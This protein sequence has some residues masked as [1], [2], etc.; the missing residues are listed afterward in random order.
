MKDW[1]LNEI[2]LRPARREDA[3]AIAALFLIAS[4]GLARYI[5]SRIDMPGKTLEEIGAAR[6]A[7]EGVAFSYRNCLVAEHEGRVVGMLHSFPMDRPETPETESD[8]VLRPYAELEDYGSLYISGLAILPAYCG[9]GLGRSLLLAAHERAKALGRPR[10][11]LI[12]FEAN[13]NAMRLYRAEGY[14]ELDRRPIVPH[15][16]LHYADGE[17]VLLARDLN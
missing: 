12:C 3:A 6:Y 8:P 15:P 11:S 5:W 14:R 1:A 13:T 17:A 4:D 10:V 2:T 7:R 16:D 9:R